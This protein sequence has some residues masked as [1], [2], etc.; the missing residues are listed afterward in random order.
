VFVTL[1]LSVQF[2][3]KNEPN[4]N[5]KGLSCKNQTLTLQRI[6]NHIAILMEETNL[7]S[8]HNGRN[9]PNISTQWKKQT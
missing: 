2:P 8:V 3:C 9:K 6:T 4:V 1:T 7:I 5:L